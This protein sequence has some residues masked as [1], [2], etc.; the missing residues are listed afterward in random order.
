MLEDPLDLVG[1]CLEGQ[2]RID[3]FIGEGELTVVYKGRHLGLDAPVAIKLL[4]LPATLDPALTPSIVEDFREGGRVHYRLSRG[5]IHIAQSLGAGNTLVPR[6]GAT[7]PYVIREWLEGKPLAHELQNRRVLARRWRLLEIMQL[8]ASAAEALA[9]AHEQCEAHLAIHPWNLFIAQSPSG[10]CVKLLDFGLGR[11]R[12]SEKDVGLRVLFPAYA[13][14]EQLDPSLGATGPATD[15]YSFALVLLEALVNAPIRPTGAHPSEIL[16]ANVDVAALGAGLPPRMAAILNRAIDRDPRKRHPNARALWSDLLGLADEATR[17]PEP[18]FSEPPPLP[19]LPPALPSRRAPPPLPKIVMPKAED[20]S[21][22]PFVAAAPID[23]GAPPVRPATPP[24]A[25]Q[26]SL[27]LVGLDLPRLFAG[28]KKRWA[29]LSGAGAAALAG[30]VALVASV[31]GAA[32]GRASAAG[33]PAATA[34][35]Q[36]PGYAKALLTVSRPPAPQKV[37]FD[38]VGTREALDAAAATFPQCRAEWGPRGAGSVHLLVEPSGEVRPMYLGPPYRNTPEGA[39]IM[40]KL[41]QVRAPA[42]TGF[43]QGMNYTYRI[44][45]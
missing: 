24:V 22:S 16:A 37:A 29:L 18:V 15:V 23:E 33:A 17:T 7:V 27:P 9:F 44:P 42:F 11:R 28:P 3:E 6:T 8:L 41:A 5:T 14:P 36:A 35:A 34:H 39:C 19:S 45:W 21:L 4:N 40:E 20:D 31:G 1:D 30:I 12:D 43:P 32:E 26:P 25:S 13:A 38:W 2:V 10:R